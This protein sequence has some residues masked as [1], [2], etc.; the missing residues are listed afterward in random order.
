MPF[1]GSSLIVTTTLVIVEFVAII[2]SEPCRVDHVLHALLMQLGMGETYAPGDSRFLSAEVLSCGTDRQQVNDQ[3]RFRAG[4]AIN[5]IG[6]ID[7]A[8]LVRR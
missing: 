6:I 8:G 3:K 4:R 7:G 2:L 5:S 1:H